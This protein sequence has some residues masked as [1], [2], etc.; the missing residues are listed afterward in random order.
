M[1]NRLAWVATVI[2]IGLG[3][4][5]AWAVEYRLDGSVAAYR[6]VE[7]FGS[8]SVKEFGPVLQLGGYVS[9]SPSTSFLPLTLRGDVRMLVGQVGYDTFEQD[10]ITGALRPTK[11]DTSYLGF[12]QEGAIGLREGIESGYLEPFLGLGYRW[13]WRNIGSS[14]GYT[15]LYRLIYGR[16]GVRTEHGLGGALKFHTTFSLDPLL[17]AR[18]QIDLTGSAFNDPNFGGV[19]VEGQRVTVKNGTRP[20]WTVE[21]GI[22]QDTIDVTGYWQAVRLAESNIVMCYDSAVPA[23]RVLCSQ[24]E[25]H[26]DIFGLRVGVA[27]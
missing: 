8:R 25:S 18:E 22:R 15:E 3:W 27:F 1:G 13:W 19:L 17:R 6:W 9:G 16:I 4:V 14:A 20:G 23:A 24:P 10:L 12:T 2:V 21:M 5:P 26:Q 11:I 7:D